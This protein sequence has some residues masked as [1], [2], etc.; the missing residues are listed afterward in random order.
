MDQNK[1]K[2]VELLIENNIFKFGEFSLK[3]GKKSWF[4]IDLRLISSFPDT[5]EYVST[6]IK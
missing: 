1:T 2:L 5:F 4:Y 6:Y 3:S